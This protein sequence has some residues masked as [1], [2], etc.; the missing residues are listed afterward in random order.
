M[1]VHE[2]PYARVHTASVAA[3]AG[4]CVVRGFG[5]GHVRVVAASGSWSTTL[6]V[7]THGAPCC[8][9]EEEKKHR[10]KPKKKS[11]I[12]TPAPWLVDWP[13]DAWRNQW[14]AA[15]REWAE[16]RDR[17]AAARKAHAEQEAA[18]A[19]RAREL[20]LFEVQTRKHAREEAARKAAEEAQKREVKRSTRS[21]R[22]L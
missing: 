4:P 19:A 12:S 18:K 10:A 3:G 17:Q 16:V 15:H 7:L 21:L 6:S 9:S 5:A 22:G 11:L 8:G 14:L 2:R 20:D 13:L 1:A